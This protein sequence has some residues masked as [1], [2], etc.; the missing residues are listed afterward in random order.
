MESPP[1]PTRPARPPWKPLLD[2][3]PLLVF[4]GVNA[5]WGLLA[6]TGTLVPLSVLALF[7]SW[8]IEGHVSRIALYGTIAIV[9]FGGLTLALRDE[10]FIKIKVTVINALLGAVLGVGLLRRKPLLKELMGQDLRLTDQGWSVLTLR[11]M[12]FFFGMAALNEV[13][14]RWL[15]TD[16]WVTF[17]TF[18]VIGA[19]VVFTVL[20][21]P[22]MKRFEVQEPAG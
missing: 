4:F 22:L 5:K 9:V 18:G 21:A 1:S 6:A 12:L 15:S 2:F 8:K 20:Q 19:T 14:R 16:A 11:F 10:S 3:G 17:K 13:L 7:L